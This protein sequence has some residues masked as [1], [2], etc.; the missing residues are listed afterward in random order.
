MRIDGS[1]SVS[2]LRQ[3]A[4][5]SCTIRYKVLIV[6][7]ERGINNVGFAGEGSGDDRYVETDLRETWEWRGKRLNVFEGMRTKVD[8]RK[9]EEG[10]WRKVRKIGCIRFALPSR[11]LISS[12]PRAPRGFGEVACV[13]LRSRAF[14]GLGRLGRRYSSARRRLSSGSVEPLRRESKIIGR[15]NRGGETGGKRRLEKGVW[16]LGGRFPYYGKSKI[17]GRKRE[18]RKR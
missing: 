6:S 3:S 14:A 16:Q 1:A 2:E 11:F 13:C 8:G 9:T 4:S 7:S 17:D 10:R 12:I 15:S 18:R 5:V